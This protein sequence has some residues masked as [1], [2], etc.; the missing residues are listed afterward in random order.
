VERSYSS[1]YVG[2][3]DWAG[4]ND[5]RGGAADAGAAASGLGLSDA[6]DL[7][8]NVDRPVCAAVYEGRRASDPPLFE[9]ILLA[10]VVLDAEATADD[11]GA[12]RVFFILENIDVTRV[13][14][15]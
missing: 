7:A 12:A 10:T 3:S 5:T 2:S 11:S 4:V 1:A 9:V 14:E 13:Y 8:E 15:D 6:V